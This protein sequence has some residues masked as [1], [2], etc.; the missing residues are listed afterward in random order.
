M[1][2]LR[3]WLDNHASPVFVFGLCVVSVILL[4]IGWSL[5]GTKH[6]VWS[7]LGI[8]LMQLSGSAL[9]AA[10]ATL[11]FSLQDVQ[12]QIASTAAML[13]AN[14]EMLDNLSESARD[15]LDEQLAIRKAHNLAN[16]V[17]PT[18]FGVLNRVRESAIV[19]YHLY[20]FYQEI[21]ISADDSHPGLEVRR[22]VRRYRVKGSHLA[23]NEPIFPFRAR[24]EVVLPD[25]VM[26]SNHEILREFEVHVGEQVLDR[27]HAEIKREKS[28]TTPVA[29]ITCTADFD[30]RRDID[31][32]LVATTV[33]VAP[34]NTEVFIA[35]Y[36]TCGF[37]FTIRHGD[38]FIYDCAWFKNWGPQPSYQ[39]GREKH[40]MV[41]NGISAFTNDWV[42]PGEGIAISW[43]QR[44]SLVPHPW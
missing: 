17:D 18:L 12:S 42:L 30:C 5:S 7:T 14:G 29:T 13:I 27:S 20:N 19:S 9:A 43:H 33:G 26:L 1:A 41:P 32:N 21:T 11:F 15:R 4:M 22:Y 25:G 8:V 28:G 23:A 36:P 35:R 6:P 24:F 2:R 39:D 44:G 3:R 34:A 16:K 37:Q 40:Q 38:D 10:I 31:L